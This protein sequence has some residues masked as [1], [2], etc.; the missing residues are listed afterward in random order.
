MDE[1]QWQ[2]FT[3]LVEQFETPL[4][5]SVDDVTVAFADYV[6]VPLQLALVLHIAFTGV[7]L[8]QEQHEEAPGIVVR[9]LAAM[10]V[11]VWLVTEPGTYQYYVQGL[12]F[13]ILPRELAGALTNGGV[14]SPVTASS[15]DQVWLKAWRGGLEVWRALGT[16][17]LGEKLL[18]AVYWVIALGASA[19]FF[20]IW[21]ISRLLLALSIAFGPLLIGLALFKPTRAVFERWIG[22]MLTSVLLQVATVVL[23]YITLQ[24]G[25]EIV[26]Q[27]AAMANTDPMN[28]LQVLLAGALFFFVAGFVALHLP[29][30]ASSLAGGLHFHTNAIARALSGAASA[31]AAPAR[32]V[33]RRTVE[34]AGEAARH[35]QRRLRPPPGGSLSHRRPPADGS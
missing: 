34:H 5:A 12:F 17:D 24:V 10:V 26:G 23:L 27:V 13:D 28:M 19:I 15:F 1:I 6:R 33:T 9:R 16:L 21:L 14:V 4:L 30:Y 8:L 2:V 35:L 22:A 18:V 7:L 31:A 3:F 29:A 25:N 11:V 32:E 20:A